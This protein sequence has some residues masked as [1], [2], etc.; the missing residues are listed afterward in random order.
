[1][2]NL[3]N[4]DWGDFTPPM[5]SETEIKKI[6]TSLRKRNWKIIFTSIIL[7]AALLTGTI[8]GVTPAVESLYWDP[9][10]C[11][12]AEGISDLNLVLSAYTELF[13]PGWE[14][15]T[16]SSG[17][18]EFATYELSIIRYDI[19]KSER[20]YL[21]GILEK[22]QLGWDYR[23]ISA[24]PA[25]DLFDRASYPFYP[26]LDD[27]RAN[28]VEKLSQL[29]EYVTVEAA[30]SFAE[31]LN[32]EQVIA[33]REEYSLPI[34]WVAIRNAP[35]DVQHLP[36]CG[37]DPFTGGAIYFD[38]NEKYPQFG[39]DLSGSLNFVY[40]GEVLEQHF[41]SLLQLS[42]DQL[43]ADRGARVYGGDRNYYTEVLEYVEE[44][45]VYSYGCIVYTTPQTLL[46]LLENE[47]VSQIKLMDG[48][49][50]IG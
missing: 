48:W 19:A 32:M 50:D 20:A 39:V 44:N 15:E 25:L 9:F 23:F 47:Q 29:P 41:K 8:Y 40:T 14:I 43:E 35:M 5:E 30:I 34:T 6:K 16:V 31:D 3:E 22:N 4:M 24:R 46:K 45:G 37:M 49:I 38:V 18:T 27:E 33:F 10:D 2:E 42:S 17:R 1:M 28:T 21:T 11:T 7:I 13:Q 26:M 36:L 12:V